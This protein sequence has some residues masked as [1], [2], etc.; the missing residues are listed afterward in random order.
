MYPK[1]PLL[2][3]AACLPVPYS[4]VSTL[5]S[6]W[7]PQEQL[8]AETYQGHGDCHVALRDSVHGG[9]DHRGAQPDVARQLAAHVHL[10]RQDA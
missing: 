2:N 8:R 5:P 10:R 9:A 7:N 1:E 3:I 6:M 4:H